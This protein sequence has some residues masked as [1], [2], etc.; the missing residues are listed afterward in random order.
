M[1]YVVA[2]ACRSCVAL[3]AEYRGISG[4]MEGKREGGWEEEGDREARGVE[5]AYP[6]VA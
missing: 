3:V 1:G 4:G 5:C 2:D 6:M